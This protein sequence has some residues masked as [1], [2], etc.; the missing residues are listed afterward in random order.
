MKSFLKNIFNFILFYFL[1]FFISFMVYIISYKISFQDIPPLELTDSYSLNDKL[2]FIKNKKADIVCIGSSIGLN[3][4]SSREVLKKHNSFLN[5]SSWGLS[6]IDIFELLKTY[7]NIYKPN[8]LIMCSNMI[9]FTQQKKKYNSNEVLEYLTCNKINRLYIKK[10]RL[11]YYLQNFIYAQRVKSAN[12]FYESLQY[13]NWGSV[14]L[15]TADFIIDT[16]RWQTSN[17]QTIAY[18]NINYSYLDSISRYCKNNKIELIFLQSPIR[19]GL[20]KEVNVKIIERH[21]QKIEDILF[22]NNQTLINSNKQI[23]EDNLFLDGTH[24]NA[25]GAKIFTKFCLRNFQYPSAK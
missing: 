23:W 1:F 16:G 17:V 20:L 2:Q 14:N 9:D 8:T 5:L 13:D 25:N 22:F 3:N 7:S 10:F 24:L 11:K 6:I 4:I 19:Q 12:N 21:I 15:D 18:N